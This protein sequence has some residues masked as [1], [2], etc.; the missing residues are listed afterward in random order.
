MKQ[1]RY[2]SADLQ[3]SEVL[4]NDDD[5]EW[6]RV[7]WDEVVN[8]LRVQTVFLVELVVVSNKRHTKHIFLGKRHYLHSMWHVQCVSK[9]IQVWLAVT[10][11]NI[12]NFYNFVARHQKTFKNRLQV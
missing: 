2:L 11:I 9:N 10:L 6:A 5:G 7:Q 4:G 3:L 12:Q 1:K 8:I